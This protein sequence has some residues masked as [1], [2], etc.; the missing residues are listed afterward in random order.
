MK[1]QMKRQAILS[2]VLLMVFCVASFAQAPLTTVAAA[3]TLEEFTSQKGAFSVRLPGKPEEESEMLNTP[4]GTMKMQMF[5]A[6][7]EEGVFIVGA[8][9]LPALMETLLANAEERESAAVRTKFFDSF[10]KGMLS[11]M[12]GKVLSETPITLGDHHGVEIKATVEDEALVTLRLYQVK[13][14]I[15]YLALIHHKSQADAPD[16]ASFFASFK[17]IL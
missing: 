5:S 13:Q 16:F 3:T 2:S 9:E 11:E 12:K 15:Y 8:M 4:L 10:S 1:Q 6:A 14:R 17:P 7:S